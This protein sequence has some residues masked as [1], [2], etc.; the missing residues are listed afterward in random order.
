M[1]QFNP[2]ATEDQFGDMLHQAK[3]TTFSPTL[4]VGNHVVALFDFKKLKARNKGQFYSVR[5]AIVNS[6]DPTCKPGSIYG[7]VF[8]IEDGDYTATNLA[9]AR[10]LIRSVASLPDNVDA[11]TFK[12]ALAQM[13]DTRALAR[14][15]QI[16][17]IGTPR[18]S[19]KGNAYAAVSYTE[20]P[21]SNQQIAEMRQWLEGIEGDDPLEQESQQPDIAST[22]APAQPYAQPVRMDA[23]PAPHYPPGPAHLAAQTI[24]LAQVIAPQPQAQPAAAPPVDRPFF[25][26][27]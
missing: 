9:R 1:T 21:Q 5:Y 4:P 24:P 6:T 11:P 18:T 10:N 2:Q 26:Q 3:E 13:L 8:F 25:G 22:A 14:G 27:R 20:L 7:D 16:K 17:A 19:K 15:V 23:A 12:A